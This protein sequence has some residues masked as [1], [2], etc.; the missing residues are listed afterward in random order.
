[1]YLSLCLS[2]LHGQH[3]LLAK[4][5]H[6]LELVGQGGIQHFRGFIQE[7]GINVKVLAAVGET[8]GGIST[9]LGSGSSVIVLGP[10]IPQSSTLLTVPVVPLNIIDHNVHLCSGVTA[11]RYTY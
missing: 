3:G 6:V 5:N 10:E 7:I 4:V 1:M 9:L 8:D 2:S 11:R